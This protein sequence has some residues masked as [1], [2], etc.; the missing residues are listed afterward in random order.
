[1][2]WAEGFVYTVKGATVAGLGVGVATRKPSALRASSFEM[3]IYA[4]RLVPSL[5]RSIQPNRLL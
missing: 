4:M 1:M 5:I 3:E 2:D